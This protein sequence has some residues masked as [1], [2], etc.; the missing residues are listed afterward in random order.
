MTV[1]VPWTAKEFGRDRT[2]TFY[3]EQYKGASRVTFVP[4]A[5]AGHFVMLDQPAAF[6][7]ALDA[8]VR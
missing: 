8:F 4:I 3:R 7:A 5:D 2:M 1:V 6:A